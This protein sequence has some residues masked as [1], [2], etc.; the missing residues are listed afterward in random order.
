MALTLRRQHDRCSREDAAAAE[1]LGFGNL[2][3]AQFGLES[4]I[5][6]LVDA[7]LDRGG[8]DLEDI[9]QGGAGKDGVLG[10]NE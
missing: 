4:G 2:L 3:A 1:K 9:K 5:G 8:G 6:S 10:V 7:A